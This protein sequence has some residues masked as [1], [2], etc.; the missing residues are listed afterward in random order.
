M[1]V[2]TGE[3]RPS[4]AEVGYRWAVISFQNATLTWDSGAAPVQFAARSSEASWAGV[5]TLTARSGTL[6]S[7]GAA[8]VADGSPRAVTGSF[9]G[10]LEARGQAG[11]VVTLLRLAGDLS[12]TDLRAEAT[13]APVPVGERGGSTWLMVLVAVAAG[14]IVAT[15]AAFAVPYITKRVRPKD[16]VSGAVETPAAVPSPGVEEF[17]RLA[18]EAMGASEWKTARAWF[19]RVRDLAPTSRRV[20]H[21]AAYCLYE[22]GDLEG[23]LGEYRLLTGEGDDDG[24]AAFWVAFILAELGRDFEV[25]EAHLEDALRKSPDFADD[26][27]NRSANLGDFLKR[28]RIRRAIR[29]AERRLN[30][31]DEP[32]GFRVRPP[33]RG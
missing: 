29:E 9:A 14:A 13:P 27:Q 33:P 16:A 32:S 3:F 21:D 20:R 26:I 17:T 11:E 19:L 22:M 30:D 25:A 8:Y 28:P 24:E 5:V 1:F 10:T 4:P 12:E 15:G 7:E 18:N 6:R 31:D 23:A 2:P